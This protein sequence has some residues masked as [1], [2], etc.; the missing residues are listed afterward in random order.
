M[1]DK[2]KAKVFLRIATQRVAEDWVR[3]GERRPGVPPDIYDA[4]EVLLGAFL[5]VRDTHGFYALYGL[6]KGLSLAVLGKQT[7]GLPEADVSLLHLIDTVQDKLEERDLV[8]EA[9]NALKMIQL[10]EAAM[11]VASVHCGLQLFQW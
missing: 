9:L 4:L 5:G 11:A 10:V 6:Y 1:E 3:N 7:E 8:S 2:D